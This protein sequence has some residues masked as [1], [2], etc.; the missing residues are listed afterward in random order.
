MRVGIEENGIVMRNDGFEC[1]E[2]RDALFRKVNVDGKR[3]KVGCDR[4]VCAR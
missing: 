4:A 1:E 2:L 3:A